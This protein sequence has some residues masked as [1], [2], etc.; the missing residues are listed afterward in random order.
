[1]GR[2]VPWRR[3]KPKVPDKQDEERSLSELE[4]LIRGGL[5]EKRLSIVRVLRRNKKGGLNSGAARQ[6]QSSKRAT[7]IRDFYARCKARGEKVSHAKLM[8]AFGV[9]RSTIHRALRDVS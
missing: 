6:A 2:R 1:M 5:P 7:E 4:R 3:H 9:S 8:K